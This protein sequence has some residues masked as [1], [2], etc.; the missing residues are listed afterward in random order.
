MTVWRLIGIIFIF[1]CTTI[2]WGILGASIMVRT[3]SGYAQLNRQVEG[4]WGSEHYQ[5]APTITLKTIQKDGDKE[6]EVITPIELES[7][8]VHVDLQLQHRRKGLLW[9]PTYDVDFDARYTF[10]N[11]LKQSAEATVIFFFPA[12]ASIYDAFEFRVDDIQVTPNENNGYEGIN[13][14]VEVPPGGEVPIHVAYK[15]RGLDRWHYSFSDGITTVKN[16]SLKA[17]TDFTEYDFPPQTISPSTKTSTKTGW[18]LEWTFNNLVSDFD[19]GIQMPNKLN[20][21]PLA[22]RMSYFA[23]VSLLFFFTTL[24]VLGAVTNRNLHPMHY[25]F[26]GASFFSFHILFAYLVDHLLLELSFII[27]ALVSMALV[28][29][30]LYRAAGAR[31]AIWAG[32]AQLVF[33][34]L[35][36]YAFF[37]EGYTGLVIT[38]GAIL[39][40]AIM[41]QLT[42]KVDWA[43]VFRKKEPKEQTA[44]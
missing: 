5:K 24:I 18:T 34:V 17:V 21:G 20:P 23:P 10:K 40:L 13:A 36:S 35:F 39:T 2:A 1:V 43:E 32:I 15:S 33:L 27:A 12:S 19:I 11:P 41:M 22:S 3:D 8:N 38:I 4:L 9:Y 37:F 16:F 28:V 44:M 26:L 14:V 30:Y 25:F 42:A 6:K 7:S 31:F 29:T